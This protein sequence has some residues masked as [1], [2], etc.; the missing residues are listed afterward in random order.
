MLLKKCGLYSSGKYALHAELKQ[1]GNIVY[2]YLYTVA[3]EQDDE[4]VGAALAL[5]NT[6]CSYAIYFYEREVV[7]LQV[8]KVFNI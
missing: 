3:F 6:Y 5:N 8:L 7:S 2:A 4:I 1:P